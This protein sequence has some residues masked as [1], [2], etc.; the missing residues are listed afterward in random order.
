MFTRLESTVGFRVPI[1]TQSGSRSSFLSS[2]ILRVAVQA[3]RLAMEQFGEI[4]VVTA[5]G[6][7]SRHPASVSCSLLRT[8]LYS[9]CAVA[10]LALRPR[11]SLMMP[12]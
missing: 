10:D 12:L 5:T 6:E 11:L 1:V 7:V 9:Y 2:P 8:L 4:N 3:A